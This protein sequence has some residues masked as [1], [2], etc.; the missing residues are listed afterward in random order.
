MDFDL[1][2]EQYL[3]QDTVRQYVEAECPA[4]KLRE[5]F[6]GEGGHDDALWNGMVEMGLAGLCVPEQ[7]GGAGLEVLDLALVAEVLGHHATPG[8][9]FGHS[10][11]CV[12]IAAG[13]SAAQKE[14]WLPKLAAGELV[15][16]VALGEEGGVWLPEQWTL[17]AGTGLTGTKINV[18]HAAQAGLFVVGLEGGRLGVVEAGASGVEIKDMDGADRTRRISSLE[19][20]DSPCELLEA[21]GAERLRDVGLVLLAADAF[22]GASR[23]V[24]MSVDY[25]K[26]R[27]QFGVTIAHFQALK[28]QLANMAVE[29]EPT[30]ALYWYAAHALDHGED[31][32]VRTAALAK[33]HV[34]DRYLQVAR[35]AVEAHGGIGFTW[36]C[37]VQ[38]W[39]KRAMFDRAFLGTP[40]VHRHR[41]ADLAGW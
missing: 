11:A 9:Y 27:E 29:V 25:A 34:T 30:R 38:I 4:N 1:S 36:E 10:L 32:A 37:D 16:S 26:A 7:Y 31:E 33:A 20:A 21:G 12:A 23:L 8:P 17:P 3:L 39:F 40:S 41:A 13:G 19:L 2:E 35:D 6:D 24:D 14:K 5:I 18:P 15:G 22:G 28:H